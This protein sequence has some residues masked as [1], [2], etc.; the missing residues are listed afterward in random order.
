[1]LNGYSVLA[2]LPFGGG[3]VGPAQDLKLPYAGAISGG[4]GSGVYAVGDQ[5][6][7][8]FPLDSWTHPQLWFRT[9]P[10]GSLNTDD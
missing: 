5:D 1:M 9:D 7:A 10:V 4:L 2:R 3:G 6:G 8:V